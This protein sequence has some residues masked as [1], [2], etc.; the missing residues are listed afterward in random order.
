MSLTDRHRRPAQRGKSTAPR[1]AT[2]ALAANCRFA[3]IG[4]TSVS[5]GPRPAATHAGVFG[6]TDPARDRQ[7]PSHRRDRRG[8]GGSGVSTLGCRADH[9][10]PGAFGPARRSGRRVDA[11]DTVELDPGGSADPREGHLRSRRVAASGPATGLHAAARLRGG[12]QFRKD[13]V[14]RP[15]NFDTTEIRELTLLTDGRSHV[16]SLDD[17]TIGDQLCARTCGAGG[18]CRAIFLDALARG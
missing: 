7:L 6:R 3:A 18:P 1:R 5:S 2:R 15:G 17:A 11:G 8:A 16:F 12:A 10:L 13:P 4:L 14:V 9:H